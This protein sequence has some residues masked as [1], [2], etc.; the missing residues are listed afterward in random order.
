MAWLGFVAGAWAAEPVQVTF[1]GAPP[2]SALQLLADAGKLDFIA[3]SAPVGASVSGTFRAGT[4]RQLFDR[5][6]ADEGYA[7]SDAGGL[8]L[9][10]GSP[11][12]PA[13]PPP[14][15]SEG[16]RPGRRRPLDAEFQRLPLNRTLRFVGDVLECRPLVAWEEVGDPITLRLHAAP[17]EQA[18]GGLLAVE[19]E[20]GTCHRGGFL[21]REGFAA[22]HRRYTQRSHHPWSAP[23]LLPPGV[24]VLA[25]RG[26]WLIDSPPAQIEET[27]RILRAFVPEPP[28][29]MWTDGPGWLQGYALDRLGLV[30]IVTG[31]EVPRALVVDPSGTSHTLRVGTYVGRDWG[32]VTAIA[33]TSVTVLEEYR[34]VDGTLVSNRVVMQLGPP[35]LSPTREA[36]GR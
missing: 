23:D 19:G 6:A 10:S 25:R 1:A 11:R 4:V 21:T 13:S 8:I 22:D 34:L 2:E 30:G 9:L 27:R 33:E 16:W 7:S 29:A 14:K 3:A 31:I 35:S 18:L 32:K 17:A 20:A 28:P 15:V 26:H 5:I 24:T 36:G 12:F